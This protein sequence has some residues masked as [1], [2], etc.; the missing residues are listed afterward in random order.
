ML[1]ELLESWNSVYAN[2][3][4]L[5]TA[6]EFAHVGGLI[7]IG[8][9]ALT[10]DLA[11]ITAAR[12]GSIGRIV[13]LQ[14]LQRTHRI[15]VIGLAALFVSGILLF[16]ADVD[17]YLDSPI[18]WTKMGLVVLLLFNDA[19]LVVEEREVKRGKAPKWVGL[20][21]TATASL[22]LWSLTTLAG[23]ALLNIG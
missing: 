17:T 15:V 9:C 4:A 10:A 19:L 20:H 8:G 12:H 13:E 22:V 21:H 11:A 2:H 1:P 5:R 7:A 14:L 23:V 18:F 16:A 6:I 3:P